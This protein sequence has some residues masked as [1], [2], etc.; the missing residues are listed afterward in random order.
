[1]RVDQ[2]QWPSDN[3]TFSGIL[4]SVMF[5]EYCPYEL[6]VFGYMCFKTVISSFFFISLR[7]DSYTPTVHIGSVSG[8]LTGR[9]ATLAMSQLT[10]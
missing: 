10:R 9:C 4:K 6:M 8:S 5:V 2:V 3:M 1:M 7:S